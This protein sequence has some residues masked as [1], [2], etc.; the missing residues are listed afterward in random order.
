MVEPI[1][2]LSWNPSASSVVRIQA[3]IDKVSTLT[4][5]CPGGTCSIVSFSMPKSDSEGM[6]EGRLAMVTRRFW[7]AMTRLLS[8]Q[9]AP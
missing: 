5:T 8:F 4:S 7:Y 1:V 6:P 3:S 9:G 2:P